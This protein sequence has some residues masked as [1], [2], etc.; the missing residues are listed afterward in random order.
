M[1]EYFLVLILVC[2]G[3]N[4]TTTPQTIDYEFTM[5]DISFIFAFIV[6]A[7]ISLIR[8][9]L[10]C[11]YESY[12]IHIKNIQYGFTNY[13]EIG[14]QTS[15]HILSRIDENPR[16]IIIIFSIITCY[17]FTKAIWDQSNDVLFSTF[18]FISWGYYFLSFNTIRN[19]FALSL[20]IFSIKNIINK[21]YFQ[22]VFLI[23]LASLFH[24]S[25]LFC[26]PIYY[27]ATFRYGKNQLPIIVLILLVCI[28]LPNQIRELMFLLYPGYEGTAYDANRVSWLNVLRSFSVV[29]LCIFYF[30]YIKD[31]DKI[32]FYYNLN[33]FSLIYYI[34][35]YWTPEASRLGFYMN[36]TSIIL[37]P[38]ILSKIK[39]KKMKFIIK[40]MIVVFS[41][42]LFY[43]MLLE[44]YSSTVRLLP[45]KTWLFGGSY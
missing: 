9:D 38:L 14:F 13:M 8:D 5:E 16:F 45:Y 25:A 31:D 28:M 42:S 23:I 40:L 18:I 29:A 41:L 26:L 33:L 36:S 4:V 17:F 30:R 34:G 7:F 24:K 10:G 2:L 19:F 12:L 27:L 1:I 37:L 44:F 20:A 15:I 39:N 11:D 43:L 3:I 21:K 6:L 32:R 22:F 35:L